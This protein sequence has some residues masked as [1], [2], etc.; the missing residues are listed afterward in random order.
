MTRTILMIILLLSLIINFVYCEFTL[1]ERIAR[2]IQD[3]N[4]NID[5]VKGQQSYKNELNGYLY[6]QGCTDKLV[7]NFVIDLSRK[8]SNG[9]TPK[10]ILQRMQFITD[11]R[12]VL[13]ESNL[14]R[15][16]ALVST[17]DAQVVAALKAK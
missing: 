6:D 12:L 4:S 9:L 3:T 2:V 8:S 1:A 5:Y 15:W 11:S 17:F 16:S 13:S 14:Q 7:Q 10:I